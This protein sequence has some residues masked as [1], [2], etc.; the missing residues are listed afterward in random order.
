MFHVERDLCAGLFFFGQLMR[1]GGSVD[2]TREGSLS[3]LP[4]GAGSGRRGGSGVLQAQF[5]CVIR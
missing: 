5:G 4:E 2:G 1:L 3:A